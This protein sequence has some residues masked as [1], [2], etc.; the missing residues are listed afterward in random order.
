[1]DQETSE[2]S[3]TTPFPTATRKPQL[4]FTQ[5][6]FQRRQTALSAPRGAAGS[7]RE[8]VEALLTTARSCTET[9]IQSAVLA[10]KPVHACTLTGKP[11]K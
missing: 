6:A 10:P 5:C 3:T 7:V 1:M 8:L 2:D 4:L 11:T 9:L